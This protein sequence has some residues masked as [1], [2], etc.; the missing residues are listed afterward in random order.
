MDLQTILDEGVATVYKHGDSTYFLFPVKDDPYDNTVYMVD[1][2]GDVEQSYIA[3][4]VADYMD[5]SVQ[6][7]V[8]EFQSTINV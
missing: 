4:F 5:D 7:D 2:N 1:S 6:I 8:D 3:V